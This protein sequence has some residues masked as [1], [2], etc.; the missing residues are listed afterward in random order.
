[1]QPIIKPTIPFTAEAFAKNQAEFDRLTNLRKEVMERLKV[2]REMGDLS[3]N[4][5]YTAA[6][7]E[8]GNIARQLRYLKHVL[9][10]GYVAETG[11]DSHVADFGKKIVLSDGI[12]EFTFL[13]VSEHESNMAEQKLSLQSPIGLA[14][15]GKKVGDAAEVITPRG[16]VTYTVVDIT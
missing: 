16:K 13:L 6:K 9:V 1:M 12:T 10:N 4:G 11:S 14:V 8:L 15:K 7:F 5:A 3:E 2:A